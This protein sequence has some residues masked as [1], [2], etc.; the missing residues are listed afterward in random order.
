MSE[1]A[2]KRSEMIEDERARLLA[3]LDQLPE[4]ITITFLR[5]FK[6]F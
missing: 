6:Q 4:G 1:M 5:Q 2:R 3:I